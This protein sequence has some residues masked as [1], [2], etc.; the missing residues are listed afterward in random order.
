MEGRLAP[1]LWEG[2]LAPTDIGRMRGM[3]ERLILAALLLWPVAA[4]AGQVHPEAV[5]LDE[6][7]AR[8]VQYVLVVKPAE[9]PSRTIQIPV[10]GGKCGDACPAFRVHIKRLVVAE[11]LRAPAGLKGLVGET[12][13]V[14]P[15]GIG[16]EY[17]LHWRYYVEGVSKSPIIPFYERLGEGDPMK[18]PKGFIVFVARD[19]DER[20]GDLK[21]LPP[22]SFVIDAALQDIK[23]KSTILKMLEK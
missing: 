23:L 18:D 8:G 2:S 20:R 22:W 9:S 11:V 3:I 16:S 7:L 4:D 10:K 13:E 19:G 5:T 21:D 6:M 15:A 14:V 17:G 12:I 1:M